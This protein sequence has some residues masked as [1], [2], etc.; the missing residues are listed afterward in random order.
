MTENTANTLKPEQAD[1]FKMAIRKALAE[2]AANDGIPGHP[3]S[4]VTAMWEL[5]QIIDARS[6]IDA[7]HPQ[8]AKCKLFGCRCTEVA[9]LN[10]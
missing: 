5:E 7:D 9:A 4:M 2:V 6:L 8:C 10:G 1:A 3:I